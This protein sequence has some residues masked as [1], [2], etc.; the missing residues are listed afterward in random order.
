MPRK[1]KMSAK[2]TVPEKPTE[3]QP[4]ENTGEG[5]WIDPEISRRIKGEGG[6]RGVEGLP[7]TTRF[8]DYADTPPDGNQT[9][10]RPKDPKNQG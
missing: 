9:S 4:S 3:A 2:T 6:R 10:Q 5:L 7:S 8:L 1:K